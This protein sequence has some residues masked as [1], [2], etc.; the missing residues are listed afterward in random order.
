MFLIHILNMF[1]FLFSNVAALVQVLIISCLNLP[2]H[3]LH[4]SL[5]SPQ[6]NQKNGS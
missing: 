2:Q 4:C 6:Y 1:V 5:A 3:L